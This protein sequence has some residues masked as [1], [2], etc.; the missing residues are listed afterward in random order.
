MLR[1]NETYDE[2]EKDKTLTSIE[3]KL[4]DVYKALFVTEY[5]R[6][7]Y[8]TVIGQYEFNKRTKDIILKTESLLSN[9]ANMDMI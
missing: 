2:K 3:E 6:D 9:Y 4:K 1:S 8:D 5:G 7:V